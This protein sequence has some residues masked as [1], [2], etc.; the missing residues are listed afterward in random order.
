MKVKEDTQPLCSKEIAK[1]TEFNS[2]QICVKTSV[3]ECVVILDGCMFLNKC[4][5]MMCM[6]DNFLFFFNSIR[7]S[8]AHKPVC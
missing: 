5:T 2:Y 7:P 1:H 8:R 3:N 6:A 4:P